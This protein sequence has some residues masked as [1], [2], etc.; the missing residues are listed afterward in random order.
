[1][2]GFDAKYSKS[3]KES[4]F[5][6]NWRDNFVMDDVKCLGTEQS[7]D[8]CPHNSQHDCKGE[9]GA[10]VVCYGMVDVLC[11]IVK[12][13]NMRFINN[14]ICRGRAYHQFNEWP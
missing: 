12:E 5:G 6:N 2:M 8:E 11:L 7:L 13:R 3:T 4:T 9:E 14:F 1:M 10:G